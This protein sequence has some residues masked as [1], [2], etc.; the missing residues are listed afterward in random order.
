M[1]AKI[2]EFDPKPQKPQKCSFCGTSKSK[3][4]RMIQSST[5][6]CICDKCL[7]K[8]KALSDAN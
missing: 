7:A 3:A 4:T 6:K 8:V 1:T 2:I 5:G